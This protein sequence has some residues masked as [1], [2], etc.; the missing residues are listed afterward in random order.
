MGPKQR[1]I[2]LARR[3][4]E[5]RPPFA[6][7]TYALS[8]PVYWLVAT[9]GRAVSRVL[10][11]AVGPLVCYLG[12]ASLAVCAG[13]MVA[14]KKET[15]L[16]GLLGL[17]TCETVFLITGYG[18]RLETELLLVV[19]NVIWTLLFEPFPVCLILSSA[20][21]LILPGVSL[22]AGGRDVLTELAVTVSGLAVAALGSL[23]VRAHEWTID[24]QRYADRLEGNVASLTRANVLS[25][26][27]AKD[28]EMESRARERDRLTRDIHDAIGY[29][30]TNT[31]MMVEAIKVMVREEPDRVAG[32]IKRIRANT[33]E[34]LAT[35]KKILRDFRAREQPEESVFWAI[36]KLVKVF[37]VS[38]GLEVRYEL[39][40]ADIRDLELF[41]DAV[42]HFIQEGLINAFRHGRA[43]R[44]SIILW[45]FGDRLRVV[46]DDNG[47]GCPKGATPGI[48]I[49]GMQERAALAGGSVS[50]DRV[51]PGF[52]ISMHLP[53][54]ARNGKQDQAVDR[55]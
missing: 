44:V 20:T 3:L 12:I 49:S 47:L 17:Y 53:L 7:G 29:T 22:V 31:I 40:N 11:R 2:R 45:N 23:L 6:L 5:W 15:S 33:E 32:H 10:P 36:K 19:A 46:L 52:R 30:M 13:C 27:Y 38:T 4:A 50:I 18:L 14:V 35:I 8:L 21:A 39:G 16:R 25:Q 24:L 54:G 9:D 51:E 43:T 1:V 37:T 26:N 55:G 42:Y 48:G 34:G 28:I 41:P